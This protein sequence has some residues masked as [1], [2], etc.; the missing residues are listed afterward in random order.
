MK[1]SPRVAVPGV[2][3]TASYAATHRLTA[4]R[5]V[6]PA[7]FLTRCPLAGRTEEPPRE[8]RLPAHVIVG[9]GGVAR[10]AETASLPLTFAVEAGKYDRNDVPVCVP[11]TGD[12]KRGRQL[13]LVELRDGREIA[14][15]LQWEEGRPLRAWWIVRGAMPK[16]SVGPTKM[17]PPLSAPS[18]GS[19]SEGVCAWSRVA[20]VTARSDAA[21]KRKVRIRISIYTFLQRSR[22][23]RV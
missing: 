17:L 10:G 13:R 20:A 9:A 21:C 7:L 22:N 14:T 23:E 15:P 11:L 18:M 8:A 19:I 6:T 3:Q 16:G 2:C 1:R 12:L 4:A 5:S